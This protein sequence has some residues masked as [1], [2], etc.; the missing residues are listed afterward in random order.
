MSGL[1]AMVFGLLLGLSLLAL[2][3]LGVVLG[4]LGWKLVFTDNRQGVARLWSWV[5]YLSG[6]FLFLHGIAFVYWW[7]QQTDPFRSP[8]LGFSVSR[9]EQIILQLLCT[10]VVAAQLGALGYLVGGKSVKKDARV[11]HD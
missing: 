5:M 7:P 2:V 11:G 1:S 6:A 3:A 4:W 8:P 10:A 9:V